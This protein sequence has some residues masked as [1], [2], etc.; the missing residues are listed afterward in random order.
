MEF[1]GKGCEFMYGIGKK[2][3]QSDIP[4]QYPR[5]TVLELTWERET[6]TETERSDR[7][8]NRLCNF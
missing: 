1:V 5:K 7:E 4:F 8:G 3:K 6:E 2:K